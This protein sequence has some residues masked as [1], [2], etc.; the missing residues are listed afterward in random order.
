MED[1]PREDRWDERIYRCEVVR[2]RFDNMTAVQG[3]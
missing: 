1:Q 2:P 3:P